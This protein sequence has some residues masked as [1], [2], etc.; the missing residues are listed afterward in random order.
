MAQLC[1]LVF[2]ISCVYSNLTNN[3]TNNPIDSL[4]PKV[5]VRNSDWCIGEGRGAQLLLVS[6]S[7]QEVQCS[8]RKI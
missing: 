2:T 1:Y 5:I 7:E 6:F 4:K 8:N 3:P